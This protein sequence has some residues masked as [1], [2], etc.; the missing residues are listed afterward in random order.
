MN[1][2][3]KVDSV[4]KEMFLAYMHV[5]SNIVF[6]ALFAIIAGV[7]LTTLVFKLAGIVKDVLSEGKGFQVKHF[8]ELG[9]EYMIIMVVIFM[10]PPFI[11]IFEQLL[12]Y[13]AEH[14]VSKIAPEG[15]YDHNQHILHLLERMKDDFMSMDMVDMVTSGIDKILSGVL[16]AGIG[17]FFACAYDYI[18]H[19]FMATRYLMLMLME[20]VGPIAIVCL[21]N[22][23]TRSSFF[24]WLKGMFGIFMLYPGFIIASVF[25][26]EYVANL[27]SADR[28]PAFIL[29]IFSFILK[30]SLLATVKAMVNK[31]L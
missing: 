25:A 15:A 19:V 17:S 16:M 31:W 7:I 11:T 8:F 18:M 10:L 14:L 6:D 1:T 2:T 22:N 9:K 26:D 21:I 4:F 23:D 24:T 30:L 5:K 3:I 27:I 29:V 20:L 13:T 12:A 28:F